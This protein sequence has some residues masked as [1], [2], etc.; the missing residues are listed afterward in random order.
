MAD[1]TPN[2][3]VCK[4]VGEMLVHRVSAG[5]KEWKLGWGKGQR[6]LP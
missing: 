3:G 1:V 5:V 6:K 4:L 2:L